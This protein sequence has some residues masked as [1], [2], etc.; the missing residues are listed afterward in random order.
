VEIRFVVPEDRDELLDLSARAFG[1]LATAERA[2]R[3]PRLRREFAEERVLGVYDA[4]RLIASGR[5]HDMEQWWHGAA[6]RMGGVASVYVAPEERGRGVGARLTA[7]LIELIADRG[8][9]LSVLYPATAPVYRRAGYEHGGAQHWISFPAD[10]LRTLGG[11]RVK[12]RRVGPADAADVVAVQRRVHEAARDAGP[13]DRGEAHVRWEFE[14]PDLYG[15]LAEDGFIAYHWNDD[16]SEFIVERVVAGSAETVRALWAVVGSGSSIAKTVRARVSPYDP[17]LWLL[18]D[19]SGEQVWRSSWML[20]L[21]DAPAAIA[22]R[23][24]PAGVTAEVA[25]IVDDPLRPV[26]AGPWRLTVSG[27]KGELIR[28]TASGRGGR[29]VRV[30]VR[31]LAA[32]YAGVPVGTLRRAGLLDGDDPAADAALD[33]AFA[34]TP[35]MLDDF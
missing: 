14:D 3:L 34:A 21:V 12:I 23:G 8:M 26:N 11:D 24:F 32:L 25:L 5:Y 16:T 10:A 2:R 13:I 15:Y 1:P 27:G 20:R 19:R 28:S 17:V 9:P 35:F 30:S 7:A 22:A 4:G 6:V 29:S 33:G 18:R 31:G